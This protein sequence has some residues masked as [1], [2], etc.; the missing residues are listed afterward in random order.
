MLNKFKKKDHA[1]GRTGGGRAPAD[2]TSKPNRHSKLFKY[3]R[4]ERRLRFYIRRTVKTQQFYW[5]VI[6]LVLLNTLTIAVEH[7]NQPDWLTDFLCKYILLLM[8]VFRFN[9]KN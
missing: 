7:D 1:F 6:V 2:P 3:K 9:T 4:Q 5:G 8:D